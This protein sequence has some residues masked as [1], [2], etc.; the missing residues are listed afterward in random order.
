MTESNRHSNSYVTPCISVCR[1]DPYTK[2]CHGCGRSL[3][4]IR[5]WTNY[6]DQQRM[7]IM[8]ALGYGKR[9]KKLSKDK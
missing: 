3:D 2:H 1:V 5:D 7:E 8:K 6:T 9:K 4:Q